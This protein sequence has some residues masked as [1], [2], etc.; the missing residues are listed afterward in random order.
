[1]NSILIALK[2][3]TVTTQDYY[4]HTL[5]GKFMKSK[6]KISMKILAI[7]KKCL[8]I[9]SIKLSHDTMMIQ[10]NQSLKK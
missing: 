3:N 1:M 6:L 5:I 4:P 7:I 8:T 10:T 9:V 2:V